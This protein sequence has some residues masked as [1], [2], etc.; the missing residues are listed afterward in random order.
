MEKLIKLMV[1]PTEIPDRI[2]KAMN[3]PSIS[4]RSKEYEKSQEAVINGVK[5]LMGTNN[6]IYITTSSG[7]GAMEA[8]IQNLF[9]LGDKVVVPIIGSFSSQYAEMCE[10]FGLQVKRIEF[11]LGE[12]A[13]FEVVMKSVNSDTKAVFVVHNESSTGVF[14]NLEAFGKSLQNTDTILITDSISGLGGLEM[15]MDEWGIDVVIATSQKALMSPPGISFISMGDKAKYRMKTSRFP[16]YY[17]DLRK[18]DSFNT[19]NQTPNT[20]S[21]Y[22]LFAVEE[23]LKMIFEEGLDSVYQRHM[24]NRN[25][26]IEGLS[27]LGIDILPN[28]LEIASPTL[29]AVKFPG[30]ADIIASKLKREGIIVNMGLGEQRNDIIRIGTMGYVSKNDLVC[31]LSVLRS[32]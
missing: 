21:V 2:L 14:N 31:L 19:K 11:E 20:P 6:D 23:A 29:T 28:R 7:T 15:K 5:K 4:H 26:L 25:Y 17:F 8:V 30:V 3:T 9:S 13:D 12:D 16:K 18:F 32:L 10:A 24:S 1:G 22:T 27:D